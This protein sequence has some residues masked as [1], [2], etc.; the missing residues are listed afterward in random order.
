[1]KNDPRNGDFRL[2]SIN[3]RPESPPLRIEDGRRLGA[4][5]GDDAIEEMAREDG[6]TQLYTEVF[7][8]GN[9]QP[10]AI[11]ANN[12][13]ARVGSGLIGHELHEQLK[14][15]DAELERTKETSKVVEAEALVLA[16]GQD[17]AAKDEADLR[18]RIRDE[19][20]EIPESSWKAL[21]FE[22][23]LL[24]F[25]GI[26]DILFI[27]VAFQILGLTDKPI[28]RFLPITELQVAAS[29][30]VMALLIS[31]RIAGHRLKRFLHLFGIIMRQRHG[32]V[33]DNKLNG[34][35]TAGAID[36]GVQSFLA[37]LAVIL[38]L[39]GVNGVRQA[40]LEKKGIPAHGGSFLALQA[41]IALAGIL[42]AAWFAHP[43]D[44]LWRSTSMALAAADSRLKAV[45]DQIT[46]MVSNYNARLVERDHIVAQY[47]EW[48]GSQL[49]DTRRQNELY[50][51]RVL[52]SQPEPT[53]VQL[54][55]DDLPTPT[56]APWANDRRQ[57][58][59]ARAEQVLTKTFERLNLDDIAD[60][61]KPA[62]T[63]VTSTNKRPLATPPPDASITGE[64][65][66][67]K[68]DPA[69]HSNGYGPN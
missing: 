1:M 45:I 26:G 67:L 3:R 49:A 55:A 13:A 47:L 41:G 58:L 17:H 35:R 66:E 38:V 9:R 10:R 62:A 27:S 56:G 12:E 5:Y 36:A 6:K 68:A 15:L 21:V 25:L 19:G 43:Y 8:E 54:L 53:T 2:P 28:A 14:E 4:G 42:L 64:T 46:T 50:G 30:S 39:L 31:T 40:F 52:L 34:Q 22:L 59:D 63:K 61:R 18:A 24:A 48:D 11:L 23:V 16:E 44:R 33:G 69:S 57:A 60:L 7:G 32:S 20:L 37:V 29:A 65:T 51:R